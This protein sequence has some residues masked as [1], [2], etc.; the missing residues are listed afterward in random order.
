MKTANEGA[1]LIQLIRVSLSGGR[2]ISAHL[3]I[4]TV[5]Y[6]ADLVNE[7]VCKLSLQ[8]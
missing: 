6:V 8:Y 7:S 2:H 4:V 3:R 5:G 1:V